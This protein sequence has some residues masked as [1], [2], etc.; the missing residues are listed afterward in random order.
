MKNP[1]LYN[2]N[3]APCPLLNENKNDPRCTQ[4][5]K[6]FEY[7][8][9]DTQRHLGVN[10]GGQPPPVGADYDAGKEYL[11]MKVCNQADCAFGGKPQPL[12][13]FDKVKN[14]ADGRASY[15]KSCRRKSYRDKKK[16]QSG[17]RSTSS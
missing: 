17:K 11:E 16:Q 3:G 10:G 4:C 13:K 12:E 6:R 14:M 5:E 1:C 2:E 15:C 7:F 8:H 9:F